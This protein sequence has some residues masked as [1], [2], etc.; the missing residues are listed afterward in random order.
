MKTARRVLIVND[1]QTWGW[2]NYSGEELAPGQTM[3]VEVGSP[4]AG[5][6]PPSPGHRALRVFWLEPNSPGAPFYVGAQFCR[7]VKDYSLAA[8]IET[9]R[10][11][12]VGFTGSSLAAYV[13]PESRISDLSSGRPGRVDLTDLNPQ[14][15][16]RSPEVPGPVDPPRSL[17][18]TT[19]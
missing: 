4:S 15:G 2:S 19:R 8:V 5:P 6:A 3:T 18:S 14:A 13:R 17:V 7:G 12:K 11:A 9:I 10:S 1:P 16:K